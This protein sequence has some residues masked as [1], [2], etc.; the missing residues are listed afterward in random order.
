MFKHPRSC[1]LLRTRAAEC[2]LTFA[3]VTSLVSVAP[4]WFVMNLQAPGHKPGAFF[5]GFCLLLDKVLC[6]IFEKFFG[7]G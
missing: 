3:V 5:L 2:T 6:K 7:L 4:P 1:G